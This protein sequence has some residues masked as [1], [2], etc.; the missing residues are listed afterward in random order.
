MNDLPLP[1]PDRRTVGNS[2]ISANPLSSSNMSNKFLSNINNNPESGNYNN[3]NININTDSLLEGSSLSLAKLKQIEDMRQKILSYKLLTEKTLF[4]T[5]SAETAKVNRCNIILFGPSGSGKSSFIK[6]LYRSIYNSPILPSDATSKLKIKSQYHNEGTINF[7]RM[8]LVEESS[9]SSGIILCDTRGHVNM[10]ED[11]KEQFKVLLD[12][13]V[14]D[15]VKVEQRRNRNPLQL[16][17]FWKRPSE[18]FP[19]ELFDSEEIGIS[20]IPHCVVFVFDGNSDEVIPKE[21]QKFYQELVNLCK[22]R[23]YTEIQVVLT[24]IDMLEKSFK[25]RKIEQAEKNRKLNVIKDY[26]IEKVL[27]ILE[28]NRTHIHF[29]ENYHLDNQDKNSLDIDYDILKAMTDILNAAEMF[30]L[31]YM[32]K[33]ESCF[34]TCFGG[35]F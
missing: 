7:T 17:E 35:G 6:S 23:G 3:N 31:R 4:F 25:N 5:P 32:S 26:K 1:M 29:L 9:S 33:R 16:W 2:G 15:G 14:K 19:P 12:K 11:E 18:L 8:K 30:I 21:D 24:R 13:N 10:N 34:A 27:Q 28:L 20:S 22:Y